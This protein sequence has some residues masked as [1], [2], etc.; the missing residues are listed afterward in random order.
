MSEEAANATKAVPT[1]ILMSIGCCWLFGWVCVIVIA[2]CINPDLESVLGSKFGQ[3]M[4]QIYYDA[5]GKNGALGFMS[6]LM[7]C[8]FMMG[9]SIIVASSRQTWAFSR[10]GALPFS[11]FFRKI[12]VKF[13]YIP[14]RAVWGCGFLAA[15]LVSI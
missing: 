14:L 6:F 11:T 2:A 7:I 1:G 15:V 4:A 9:I 5:L 10:D 8:Q 13:G 3:P 12:S